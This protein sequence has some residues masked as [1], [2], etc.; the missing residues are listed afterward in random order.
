MPVTAMCF[1]RWFAVIM[2]LLGCGL[3]AGCT[4]QTAKQ[5]P[6]YLARGLVYLDG[7]PLAGATLM[8]HSEAAINGPDGKPIPVPGA[9][10]KDDGSF[11]ASTY[12]PGDGLPV[13]DFLVTV[14]CENRQAKP[15]RDEYP[16]LLPPQYQNPAKSGL[17]V[18]ISKGRNELDVIELKSLKNSGAVRVGAR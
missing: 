12:L 1:D 8:F 14:S 10:T 2:I 11:V 17:V 6:V 18:S 5:V 15:V 13:G 7:E 9:L 4:Q 16:E 3:S